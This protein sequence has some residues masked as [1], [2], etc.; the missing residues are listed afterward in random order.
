M[1]HTPCQVTSSMS[2]LHDV[3]RT[4]PT[5]IPVKRKLLL[6]KTALLARICA[7]EPA[8]GWGRWLRQS[9]RV[10][11]RPTTEIS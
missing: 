11:T 9:E 1:V 10:Q 6:V 4:Y 3:Y 5:V 8:Q 7:C 2:F